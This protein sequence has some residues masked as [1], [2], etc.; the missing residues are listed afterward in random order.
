MAEIRKNFIS[1]VALGRPNPQILNVDFLKSNKIVLMDDPP[2]DKL[3]QQEKPFTRFISTPVMSNLVMENIEFVVD[4]GRF[5]IRDT[6]VS[7]WSETKILDIAQKYFH[8]LPY[9]PLQ[10]IGLNFNSTIMFSTPEEAAN[11]QLLFL[12]KNN[13]IMQIICEDNITAGLV[14]S[15]PYSDNGGRILLTLNRPNEANDE[16]TVNFNYEFNFIDWPNFNM[17]LA[18]VSGVGD[19]FD[20][21]LDKLLGEL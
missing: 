9:T 17:E 15:Y 8:V 3:L 19:Y 20:S 4:E 2:F 1:L 21:T 11:F 6:A 16:R 13:K 18:R 12:S 7:E 10:I 14:L 5:Q